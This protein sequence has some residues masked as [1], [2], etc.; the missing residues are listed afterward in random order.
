MTTHGNDPAIVLV[1]GYWLGARAW[2]EVVERLRDAGQRGIPLTL[3]GL[4]P[5]DPRRSSRGRSMTR[6]ASTGWGR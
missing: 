1:P 5:L 4:D 3:P 6:P 2:D